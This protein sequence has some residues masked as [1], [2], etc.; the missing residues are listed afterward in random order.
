VGGASAGGSFVTGITTFLSTLLHALY[1]LI[2]YGIGFALG[3]WSG[4]RNAPTLRARQWMVKVTLGYILALNLY[5][6]YM[7][8]FLFAIMHTFLNEGKWGNYVSVV[9]VSSFAILPAFMIVTSYWVNRKWRRIVEEDMKAGSA[10]QWS[11][12]INPPNDP[13][14]ALRSVPGLHARSIYPWIIVA[15]FSLLFDAAVY[16]V[17]ET[18]SSNSPWWLGIMVFLYLGLI[19][20]VVFLPFFYYVLRISKDQ[21]AFAKYPPRLPNLLAILTGE[22]KAPK[23]FRNRIN[24]WGDLWGTGWGL[25]ILH[26]IPFAFLVGAGGDNVYLFVSL[27]SLTVYFFFAVFFA[28]IPRRRYWGMIFLGVSVLLIYS[29]VYYFMMSESLFRDKVPV[30]LLYA[31]SSWYLLC[32]TLVGVSG[33]YVFRRKRE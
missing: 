22:E 32:F 21:E 25:L 18:Y 28:G 15:I 8:I 10:T 7:Q 4:I 11:D 1:C 31:L 9:Y 20:L 3:I 26:S 6:V 13:V 17:I 5:V 12:R 16:V 29:G 23:G 2:F 24:F 14:T 33:L 27:L 19:S 30:L